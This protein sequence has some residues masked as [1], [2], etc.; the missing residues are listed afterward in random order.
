MVSEHEICCV[1]ETTQKEDDK[2]HNAILLA[3]TGKS[4]THYGSDFAGVLEREGI[5]IDARCVRFSRGSAT[6]DRFGHVNVSVK[7]TV[8]GSIGGDHHDY[9]TWFFK[10]VVGNLQLAGY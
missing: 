4:S 6:V 2:W 7:I 8:V 10:T 9:T 5:K 3:A 1:S